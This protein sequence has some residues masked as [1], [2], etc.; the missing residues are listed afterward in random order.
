[1]PDNYSTF[2][3]TELARYLFF[4]NY[5]TRFFISI[6]IYSIKFKNIFYFTLLFTHNP[7]FLIKNPAVGALIIKVKNA[8]PAISNNTIVRNFSGKA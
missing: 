3:Q 1:M 5:S 8:Q 6:L 7:N 4:F 2:Y